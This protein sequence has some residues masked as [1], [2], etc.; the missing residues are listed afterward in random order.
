MCFDCADEELGAVGVRSGVGHGQ[1]TGP[2]VRQVEVLI[3]KL[4]AVDGFSAG[5]VVVG[6]ITSLSLRQHKSDPRR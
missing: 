4:V 6:E 1:N 2:C 3:L 5:S